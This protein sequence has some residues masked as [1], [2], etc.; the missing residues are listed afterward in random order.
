MVEMVVGEGMPMVESWER[1]VQL[2]AAAAAMWVEV[3]WWVVVVAWCEHRATE[4]ACRG[5]SY[6]SARRG[7][8][9]QRKNAEWYCHVVVEGVISGVSGECVVRWC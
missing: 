4:N 5:R 2:M 6:G 8:K 7:S 3:V 1:W 9:R